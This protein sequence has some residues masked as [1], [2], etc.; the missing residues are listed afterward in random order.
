A[1]GTQHVGIGATTPDRAAWDALRT[2]PVLLAAAE[3][4]LEG[5]PFQVRDLHGRNPLPGYGLQGLHAD[6]P[7][8]ASAKPFFVVTAICML[9]DFTAEN[10]ATRVVPGTH[11]LV[12]PIG[13]AL[14]Q[15]TA[16]HPAER[17][18]TGRA[19]SLLVFNGHLWHSGT[20]NESRG[21]RRAVQQVMKRVDALP[22]LG[23]PGAP[24]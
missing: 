15:P 8:R 12:R 2:H 10:G 6:W 22:P 24:S 17:V 16:H 9:D 4:V 7:P 1:D 13:R 5:A 3:H 20:R 19:G 23:L 14:G 18:V 21:P 11:L